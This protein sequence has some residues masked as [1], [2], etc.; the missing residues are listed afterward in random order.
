MDTDYL[1]VGAGASGLAFTDALVAETDVDVMVVDRQHGPGGHWQ[2]AYPF[3]RLHTPSAYYGVNSLA[4]GE[5]RIDHEGENAGFYE[6]ATGGEVR[7]H[8]AKAARRLTRTGRVRLFMHHE[9]LGHGT[10][11]EQVRDL[12][13]GKVIDVSVRRKVVDA[14]YLEA[15]I[16]ATHAMSFE[17]ASSARVIPVNDLPA[18]AQSATAYA[19]LG[20][21]KTAVDACVW[22]LDNHVEPDRV[23]WVRPR[24]AWFYERSYFQPLDQ[25]GAIME[26]ISLDA[27]A[28]AEAANVDDAFERLEA[29]GRFVRID[30][31]R[32]ATMY[33]GTMLSAGELEA[34]RQIEDVVRLGRVRR[35]EADRIVLERGEART[36][37]DV[38]HVDCT[39]LGLNNAPATAIFEPGRI[40]L[41]QVRYLS[42]SLNAALIGFVEAHRDDD[43]EKNRLCPPHAYPSTPDDWPRLMCRTWTAEGRWLREPD[44]SAWVAESRLNLMRGLADHAAEPMVQTAVERY[45][46]HVRPAMDRLSSWVDRSHRG[47]DSGR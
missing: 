12:S 36:G 40:V 38:L 2:H 9:H 27:E 26:G 31:S 30:P 13:T 16:P 29:A 32:A 5:N 37:R 46:T 3:V 18:A 15:S 6:R 4:L 42:P 28:G 34:V 10:N 44:I 35:I 19:V 14:R 33:R 22:L 23:R 1:V 11:G 39:A 8:F 20:S 41:Q 43:T 24:D 17:V 47:D 7:E 25:V 21:G 45:F